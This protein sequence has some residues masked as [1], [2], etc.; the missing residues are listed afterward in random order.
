MELQEPEPKRLS[1]P[2]TGGGESG[3]TNALMEI[4]RRCKTNT[5]A[6]ATDN[7][8]D[9][10]IR[11]GKPSTFL[12]PEEVLHQVKVRPC[13]VKDRPVASVMLSSVSIHEVPT[14]QAFAE[15]LLELRPRDTLTKQPSKSEKYIKVRRCRAVGVEGGQLAK[16]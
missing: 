4:S 8:E 15:Q 10:D 3:V 1:I 11:Y 7:C 14:A 16:R 12:D 9:R 5:L 13:Y 6:I 2:K